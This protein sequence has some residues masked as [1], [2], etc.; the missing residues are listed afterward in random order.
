MN[1]DQIKEEFGHRLMVRRVELKVTLKDV[2]EMM[3]GKIGSNAVR[4]IEAGKK[5]ISVDRV[6][7]IATAYLLKEETLFPLILQIYHPELWKGLEKYMKDE[8]KNMDLPTPNQW[9][10]IFWDMQSE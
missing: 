3:S 7:E 2:G 1:M 8:F 4:L 10:R 6:Q 9:A 5:S